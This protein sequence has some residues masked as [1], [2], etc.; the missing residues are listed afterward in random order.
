ML[1]EKIT[2]L[3]L[4][5]KKNHIMNNLMMFPLKIQRR[6]KIVTEL[7]KQLAGHGNANPV[8]EDVISYCI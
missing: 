2:S 4:S 8:K 7:T 1:K 5:R 3:P 6:N